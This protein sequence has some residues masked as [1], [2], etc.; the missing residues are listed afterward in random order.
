MAT[1]ARAAMVG[2][3]G[4]SKKRRRCVGGLVFGKGV[5]LGGAEFGAGAD[6]AGLG[7]LGK[8]GAATREELWRAGVEEVRN[9]R[10]RGVQA[11]EDC[12]GDPLILIRQADVAG[13]V[14]GKE[15]A[16]LLL[17]GEG[18]GFEGAAVLDE[19]RL[20]LFCPLHDGTWLEVSLERFDGGA[21]GSGRM[22][23]R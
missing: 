15:A 3:I 17:A 12:R 8:K 2:G 10:A 19:A 4:Q 9:A 1:A 6:Q 13:V 18:D 14:G 7:K 5:L 11:V 16:P 20:N 21:L 23:V 22:V